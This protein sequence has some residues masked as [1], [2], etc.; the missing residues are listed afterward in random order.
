LVYYNPHCQPFPTSQQV[1]DWAA[2]DPRYGMMLS[3]SM[4]A[5]PQPASA[6]FA[7]PTGGPRVPEA[8][9]EEQ[10]P[11]E[12]EVPKPCEKQT[13]T[14]SGKGERRGRKKWTTGKRASHS[15]ADS[16]GKNPGRWKRDEHNKFVEGGKL[17]AE[18]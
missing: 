2:M 4:G 7:V 8:V 3:Q 1:M 15:G 17:D 5:A 9:P 12:V 6:D 13:R 14:S 10:K 16:S 18:T 11:Q